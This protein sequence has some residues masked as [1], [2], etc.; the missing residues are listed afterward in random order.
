M[1]AHAPTKEQVADVVNIL[2]AAGWRDVCDGQWDGLRAVIPHLRR[3]LCTAPEPRA[4]HML[5]DLLFDGYA[6]MDGLSDQARGRTSWENVSDTL[7][8]IV[9]LLR[10]ERPTP[11]KEGG[12]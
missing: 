2:K 7:D 3:A 1:T 8:A 12:L 11:T 6:V 4:E 10:A 9:K 5:P